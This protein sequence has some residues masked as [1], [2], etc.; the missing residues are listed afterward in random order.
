MEYSSIECIVYICTYMHVIRFI[1]YNEY[2]IITQYQDE[3]T[4]YIVYKHTCRA[5]LEHTLSIALI[6]M[7]IKLN[8][9]DTI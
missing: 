4:H 9:N 3:S 8:V 2:N 1:N 6:A 7:L 5:Q